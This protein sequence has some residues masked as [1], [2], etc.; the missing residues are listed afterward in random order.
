MTEYTQFDNGAVIHG[1]CLEVM[2]TIPEKSMDMI[3][4][5]LPYGTTS[6][7]WDVIIPFDNLWEQYNMIIKNNKVVVLF[8]SQPF[9][10]SLISSNIKNFKEELIWLKK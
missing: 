1:D 6:C 8:S 9:T 10:S 7:K 5:D 2:A 3:L 4:C